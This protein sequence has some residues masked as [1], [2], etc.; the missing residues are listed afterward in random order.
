MCARYASANNQVGFFYESGTYATASGTLQWPGL[1]QDHTPD[2]STGVTNSRFLGTGD[3]GVGQ[4]IDGP[5]DYPGT[6][7]YLPQDWK[8]LMFALGS[9]VDAGSPSPYTHAISEEN[10]P[11]RYNAYTSGTMN[12]WLS[13]TIEDAQ[14]HNPTGLNFIRTLKGCVV[15][16][17]TLNGTQGEPL[18][19]EVGYIAQ[20][21]VYSSGAVSALTETTTRPFLWSDCKLHIPSGTVYDGMTAF[22]WSV[23]NS[24]NAKHYL[25]GSREIG[26]PQPEN[27]DYEFSPTFDATSERTKTLYDKYFLGGSTFNCMLEISASTG[28]RDAFIIMSGCKLAPMNA[29]SPNEGTN[30]QGVTIMPA[31]CNVKVNDLIFKYN[32]W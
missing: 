16:T 25:N 12:P 31:N 15:D 20:Q 1:V 3:R 19:A 7:T 2:E 5:L 27:R 28:S 32:P 10:G 22:T 24:M 14:Q 26:V 21:N 30:E 13:F 18:S 23:N 11:G 17:F 8:M 4:F 9:N 29:P 6:F